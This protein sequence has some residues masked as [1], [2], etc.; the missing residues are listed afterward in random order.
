MIHSAQQYSQVTRGSGI[1]VVRC[2]AEWCAPCKAISKPYSELDIAGVR[3]YTIDVERVEDF[4]DAAAAT[5]IPCFFIFKD[6]EQ[7][8]MVVGADLKNLV[9]QITKMQ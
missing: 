3:F 9:N 7:M 2:T 6:K 1:V 8:G 5:K 4:A